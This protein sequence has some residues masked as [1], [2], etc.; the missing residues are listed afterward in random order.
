MTEN[1]AEVE[2]RERKLPERYLGANFLIK[3]VRCDVGQAGW[4]RPEPVEGSPR[5]IVGFFVFLAKKDFKFL[6]F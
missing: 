2:K 4:N 6:E 3:V 5:V 1:R